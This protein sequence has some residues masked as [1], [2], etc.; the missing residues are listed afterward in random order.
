MA[1][2]MTAGNNRTE[3]ICIFNDPRIGDQFTSFSP[4][5]MEGKIK[6]YNAIN[7]PAQRLADFINTP[8][9]IRDVVI[10]RV[11]LAEK[12]DPNADNWNQ[13]STER[14]G[15]RVVIIDNDDV[16]YTATS[17]GIYNSVSTLR[18]VFGTLHFDEGLKAIVKQIKTKNGNTLTLALQD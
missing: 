10:S 5:T 14:E 2:T 17:N 3:G 15:F 1:T 4:D 18:S 8:I 6:L 12:V 16:S 9:Y 11:K 7:S 13:E